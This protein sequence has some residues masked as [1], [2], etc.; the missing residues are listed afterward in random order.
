MLAFGMDTHTMTCRRSRLRRK[1]DSEASQADEG[2]CNG[3]TDGPHASAETA[4]EK[5]EGGL[6]HHWKTLDEEVQWPSLEPIAFSLTVSA[7]LDHRPA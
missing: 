3:G 5:E 7:T 6:E 2:T 1:Y 4:G